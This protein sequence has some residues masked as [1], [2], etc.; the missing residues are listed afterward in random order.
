MKKSWSES[1]ISRKASADTPSTSAITAKSP[2]LARNIS[3]LIKNLNGK[4]PADF[5]K[6][7]LLGK[8]D[9]GRVYLVIENL[10][11]SDE[12]VKAPK[13][14]A[15]KVLSKT[16]MIARDKIHRVLSEQRVMLEAVH[17]FLVSLYH[18]FQSP[19]YLY[20]CME[21][22]A[23]G[24]FF[25]LLQSRPN[26]RLTVPEARFYAAEVLC[27]LEYLHLMGFIYRDLK[28]ENILIHASGHIMLADF[29]LSKVSDTQKSPNI[30]R[31]NIFQHK[32]IDLQVNTSS[33]PSSRT[34]SFVGTAEY[35]APE[36]IRMSGH[37]NM[38]D[39]WALGILLYEMLTART[40]FKGLTQKET[41]KNIMRKSP[42]CFEITDAHAK[43]LIRRLLHKDPRKRIGS[44]F[45]AVEI[46]THPF[47]KHIQWALL[48]H[49]RAPIIP[50]LDSPFDDRYFKTIA[51]VDD[52]DEV[53]WGEFER[54]KS[55]YVPNNS[56]SGIDDTTPRKLSKSASVS[57]LRAL[58]GGSDINSSTLGSGNSKSRKT[59]SNGGRWKS[60][61]LS[62]DNDDT[63]IDS[64]KNDTTGEPS[65]I[66]LCDSKSNIS[67]QEDED[68]FSNF[69][70]V[71]LELIS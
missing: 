56:G 36:I 11:S 33:S 28:P 17:P 59:D 12:I 70:S 46:K 14:Y 35:I 39:W 61:T 8:G 63:K 69:S 23:G 41:F 55:E 52:N 21:Y 10:K 7:R 19:A 2:K 16:E 37:S 51:D 15:M 60:S 66:D 20:M 67:D 31:R 25:R 18:T 47:F 13:I 5:L 29:D 65:E 58:Y 4:G 50:Q 71:S 3:P 57:M 30:V 22:C 62:L 32:G 24:E 54:I 9:V 49:Q 34:N 43:S 53:P 6:L 27:A 64:D 48:R 45:G 68:P 40:P 1:F 42:D 44:K 38:V 26:K